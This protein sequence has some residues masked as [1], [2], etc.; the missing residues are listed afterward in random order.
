[1][2]VFVTRHLFGLAALALLVAAPVANAQDLFLPNNTT[3][4]AT[5]PVAPPFTAIVGY[6][7]FDDLINGVNATSPTI[8][9]VTGADVNS[10]EVHNSSII[11][12][13]DGSVNSQFFFGELL[14]DDTSTI[15]ISGGN[16][17][18][19]VDVQ[20]AST[21]NFS[22]GTIGDD[23]VTHDNTTVNMSG[24]TVDQDLLINGSSTFNF[25]GGTV[26]DDIFVQD[27]SLLNVF[28]MGLGSVLI[29]PNFEGFYS[30]YT[31]S[32]HLLDNTVLADRII[33]VQNGSGARFTLNNSSSAVPEPGTLAF[34]MGTVCGG[35]GLLL[36][37]KRP[38]LR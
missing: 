18:G 3:L 24:G 31:L 34:L 5:N 26:G 8:S 36:R 9:I 27:S 15:N 32:G 4:D 12:M 21:V 30:E 33:F 7:S 23:I 13:S 35:G 14:S 17:G 19:D 10:L 20:S 16:V 25:S 29:D 11:N 22:G 2:S 37:R 1:M 38:N 28:G 6:A